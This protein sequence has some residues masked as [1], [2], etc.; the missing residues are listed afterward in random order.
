MESTG[1]QSGWPKS[2]LP[3]IGKRRNIGF[4]AALGK[5]LARV[6]ITVAQRASRFQCDV[7][8]LLD[9]GNSV[10]F[11]AIRL[12]GKEPFDEPRR[13]CCSQSE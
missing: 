10:Y 3:P 13:K 9:S 6:T 5:T 7:A 4:L 2:I 12:R 1:S 8:S 11:I